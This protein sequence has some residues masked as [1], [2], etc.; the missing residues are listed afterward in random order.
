V[1]YGANTMGAV[2]GALL[3]T[4][5][6]FELF[7]TRL[8]LWIAAL[9]NLL[10]AVLARNLGRNLPP[11]EVAGVEPSQPRAPP[12]A[13]TVVPA[14]IVY[15]AAAL[16]GFAFIGLELVWY[17]ALAPILGGSSFMF[18]L[19]LAVALAGIG[20]GGL[21]Y[22]RRDATNPATLSLLSTTVVLEALAI[23]L[24]FALSDELALVA[25][26]TRPMAAMGFGAL[27]TS[28]TAITL[29]FVFLPALVSGYQFPALVGLLGRG[30]TGVAR[31]VGSAY[32]SNTGGSILGALAVGFVLI[33]TVGTVTTW[34]ALVAL[35]A[36]LGVAV[37]GFELHRNRS[38]ALL[39]ALRTVSLA[40]AAVA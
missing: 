31:H 23:A 39:G 40:A 17:R 7:G 20:L 12:A 34:R 21:L 3:S 15:S 29:G 22:S 13:E 14:W 6:L 26:Y 11:V 5:V 24:P 2:V 38:R 30:R 33:P 25:A 28:W 4:F 19:V 1:L 35:L 8:S 10:V 9:V 16:V 27:V 36:A 18:G 37:L 32:A